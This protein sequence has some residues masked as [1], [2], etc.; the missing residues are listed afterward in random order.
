MSCIIVGAGD[1]AGF[2]RPKGEKDFLIAADKG[3]DYCINAGVTPDLVVG[4][5]DSRGSVPEGDNVI[6]VPEEKNDTDT[7]LALI[8]GIKRGF[9]TF[10]IYGALGGSRLSHTLAN[11]QMLSELSHLGR[12][13]FMYGNGFC[14]TAITDEG[15]AL[16]G[17]REGMLSVFSMSDV[18]NGVTISGAKYELKD[19]QLTNTFA[20]GVSN[21]FVKGS[22]AQIIV[23]DGTL[24]IIYE[25]PS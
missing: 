6:V 18:S 16:G 24:L 2:V 5:F 14:A 9:A 8:A 7:H 10:E 15:I 20:L 1:F 17:D 21:E 4:D 23:D 12:H 3:Y 25:I 11:L 19:A 22:E 13:G